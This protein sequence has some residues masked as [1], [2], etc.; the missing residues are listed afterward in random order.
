MAHAGVY[1]HT[2][3]QQK[4]RILLQTPAYTIYA[5]SVSQGGIYTASVISPAKMVSDYRSPAS[6]F[7]DAKKTDGAWELTRDITALPQ[8]HSTLPLSD[9]LYNLSLEEMCKAVEL[10]STFR[11]GKEWAGVW[12][13][14]ISYSIILSMAYLQPAV[15]M[16]S[17]LRKV[18]AKGRIIQDTGT[19]G[20]YPCSTD[21]MIWAVAAWEIY[22]ATGDEDWLKKSYR[23]IKN[24]IEDDIHV[25]YDSGTG[26]ARGES[27]F[28]DWREQTYPRWMQPADIFQSE[29]LGT[30]AVHFRA[31]QVLARMAHILK[32]EKTAQA[33]TRLSETIR[34]GIN[35]F[36]WMPG[37][38]YY[39]QYLYGRNHLI[40]SPRWE[41]LGEAL[42]IL[43]GIADSGRQREIVH[44]APMTAFGI[45]C[46]YPEIAGIPPYHNDAVWPFVETFWTWA[47]VKAGNDDAVL[48]GIGDIY[49][50]AALFLTNKENFEVS[51]GDFSG[52]QINSSNMLWSLSGNISLVHKVLFGLRFTDSGLAFEPF[53]PRAMEGRKELNHFKYRDA[54]LDIVLEGWGNKIESFKVNGREMQTHWI[55][56]GLRGVH[57]IVIRMSGKSSWNAPA[58]LPEAADA[59]ENGVTLHPDYYTVNP[60]EVRIV[61]G[62]LIWQPVRGA[63]CYKVLRNG[64]QVAMAPQAVSVNASNRRP[65]AGNYKLTDTLPA[66][67]QVIALDTSGIASFASEPL[68]INTENYSSCYQL[69]DYASKAPFDYK[70]FTGTGFV[71]IDGQHN[72]RVTLP[73][74]I[75]LAGDYIIDFRYANGNGPTNTGN[76]CAI[77]TLMVDGAQVGTIVFPQRGKN[78]W[79]N[80]GYSNPV[81]WHLTKGKHRIELYFNNYNDN[82]NGDVNQAM[83]DCMQMTRMVSHR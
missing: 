55:D 54:T 36:L 10:D 9:A 6:R 22:V 81:Q 44:N 60:P 25:I 31:N 23:I 38:G 34:N 57:K 50:P 79:S 13:R 21:R 61:D 8:F 73:V 5:D 26:L 71:E 83:I 37:K 19:G 15:A 4:G 72:R 30:N 18:N 67:Y 69:E 70:G 12:T 43:W 33:H 65:D 11:T 7:K 62:E 51:N 14:D 47:A 32:D 52:T 46:T 39:A 1:Q 28:L 75:E 66:E 16:K 74:D 82:M 63:V 77:R 49:R 29:C 3:A 78:E 24:S 40:V 45:P 59:A 17:L 56:P 20:A 41:A 27:S 53:V 48:K 68:M 76:K 80:W 2:A 58:G 64:K 42:C 35:R